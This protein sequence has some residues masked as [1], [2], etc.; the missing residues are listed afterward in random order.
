MTPDHWQ[1][2]ILQSLAM[3]IT[4]FGMMWTWRR[5]DRRERA[6]IRH[7][8]EEKQTSLHEENKKTFAELKEGQGRI[9]ARIEE[10]PLHAHTERAGPLCAEGI[11]PPR[12]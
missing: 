8:A 5:S 12:D 6:E 3:A 9:Q 4:L 7:M 2:L 1:S 10:Y 11:Y